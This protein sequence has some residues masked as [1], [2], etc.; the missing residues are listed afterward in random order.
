MPQ[1]RNRRHECFARE[2]A[3]LTPLAS[4]YAAAGY[5][6]DPQWF[7]FNASRLVNKA[8]V[9]ARIAELQAEFNQTAAL[10]AQYIQQKLLPLI[11]SNAAD[12]YKIGEDGK[13][14]LR[15][16]TELPRSLAAAITKIKFDRDTGAVTE[17]SLADKTG[18]G[19]A[20]LRSVGGFVDKFEHTGQ[21]GGPMRF[22]LA[23]LVG[24]SMA[25]RI[26]DADG[27]ARNSTSE[28][29]K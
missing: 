9:K 29:N 18:P 28:V 12:L 15:S 19:T 4:A 20:L 6:G 10:H 1:L 21:N 7:R 24:E 14:R 8:E 11:E 23:D 25:S 27:T 16:I 5:A 2:I 13:E 26:G 3:A 17:I 22:T